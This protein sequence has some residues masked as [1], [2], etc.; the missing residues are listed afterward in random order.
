MAFNAYA[1]ED[2]RR[3]FRFA[4]TCAESADDSHMRAKILSSMAHQA[5]WTGQP[6][7]GLTW[8]EHVLTQA[9]LLAA[10]EQAS[11]RGLPGCPAAILGPPD[12]RQ[13]TTSQGQR[14]MSF[15]PSDA[16]SASLPQTPPGQ[17]QQ[18]QPVA[19]RECF[20][21]APRTRLR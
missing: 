3:L 16:L 17:V 10:T 8:A 6:E 15:S 9:D 1:H 12:S 5:I 11:H 13:R 21:Q 20:P 19:V 7:E 14:T 2:A 18:A 4:V